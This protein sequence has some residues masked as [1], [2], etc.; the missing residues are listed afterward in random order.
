M[1]EITGLDIRQLRIPLNEPYHLSHRTV[2]AFDTI[3]L[4][5][6][7]EDGRTGLGE[8]TVL[9]GY[10]T[11]TVEES[12]RQVTSLGE[13]LIGQDT[14]GARETMDAALPPSFRFTRSAID[15]AI[16]TADRE[17]L[18][19]VTAPVVGILST[20]LPTNETIPALKSQIGNGFETIKVKIG[21]DPARDARRLSQLV[22]AVPA[23]IAFR[24]DANQGYDIEEAREFLRTAPTERLQLLEQPLP[25]DHLDDHARLNDETDVTIM[26]DEEIEGREDVQAVAATTAAGAVKFKLM[27]MGGWTATDRSI[28]AA[29]TCGLEV[30]LGNG[31]QSTIGCI[32]EAIIWANTGIELAGEFNGW[33][34]Q[35]NTIVTNE[36]GI[37]NDGTFQWNRDEIS[38]D[39]RSLQ[40][41]TTRRRQYR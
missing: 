40:S 37:F 25:V 1:S 3:F 23:D 2:E 10:S 27:K 39:D 8:A 24:V 17:R 13:D 18:H 30:V 9:E 28:R 21:F 26:L 38:L 5:V 33:R 34:K 11:E 12:W 14:A 4:E 20:E 6:T 31:V 7:L 36:G 16:E 29:Q 35:E 41:C 15:S 22:E 32:Y 19:P